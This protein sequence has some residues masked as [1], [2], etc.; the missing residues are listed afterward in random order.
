MVIK[1]YLM[2][3]GANGFGK[4]TTTLLPELNAGFVILTNTDANWFY[5]ALRQQL[6]N[7]FAKQTQN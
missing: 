4:Q 7:Y 5:G 1:L 3:Y 2:M 6:I